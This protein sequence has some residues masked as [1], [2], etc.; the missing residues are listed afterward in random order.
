MSRLK[1]SGPQ[2]SVLI[3]IIAHSDSEG[4]G[5]WPSKD[6]ISEKS[7]FS[8]STVQRSLSVLE[9]RKLIKRVSRRGRSNGYEI[10]ALSG[11]PSHCDTP[12]TVTPPT[13]TPDHTPLLDISL[14]SSG[15]S[16]VR[17]TLNAKPPPRSRKELLERY[18]GSSGVVLGAFEECA[19]SRVGGAM[20][21]VLVV[22]S[23]EWMEKYPVEHVVKCCRI[24]VDRCSGGDYDEAYLKGIISKE[25]KRGRVTAGGVRAPE[26]T[27]PLP[28]P[29]PRKLQ[30][31]QELKKERDRA[32]RR[33]PTEQE[34]EAI[35]RVGE[36]LTRATRESPEG[37]GG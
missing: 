25:F 6:S 34:N 14:R 17:A 27:V 23:M 15:K 24:F 20:S 8:E 12:V 7:G 26:P 18:D 13:V 21:E 5:A 9:R 16:K 19:R 3:A 4:E 2:R 29:D 11:N 35:R 10:L 32:T 36:Q 28:D 30:E 33:V 22:R 31:A 1:L 37:A